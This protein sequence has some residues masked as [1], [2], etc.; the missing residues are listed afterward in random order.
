VH[1][2]L[3]FVF[4]FVFHVQGWCSLTFFWPTIVIATIFA[5]ADGI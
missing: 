5:V 1:A 4:D 3:I 2:V